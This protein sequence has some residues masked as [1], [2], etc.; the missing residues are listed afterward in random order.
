MLVTASPRTST[1]AS[2]TTCSHAAMSQPPLPT[3]AEHLSIHIHRV[4]AR[5]TLR[6]HVFFPGSSLQ[7]TKGLP[8]QPATCTCVRGH[9]L[10]FECALLNPLPPRTS[11]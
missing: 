10:N 9:V 7:L 11:T 3:Y 6:Q 4:D 2:A 1:G 5:E 8:R